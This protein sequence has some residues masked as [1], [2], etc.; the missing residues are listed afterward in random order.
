[1]GAVSGRGHL[2]HEE[3]LG[4]SAKAAGDLMC[5]LEDTSHW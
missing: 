4:G 1:M 3:R 2:Q 5:Q